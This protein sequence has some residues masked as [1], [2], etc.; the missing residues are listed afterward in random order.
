MDGLIVVFGLGVGL[1][2]GTTGVGGRSVMTPLLIL[3]AGVQPV[4]AVGTDLAHG[5]VTKTLGGWQH[6]RQGSVSLGISLWMAAGS[7]PA[8]LGGCWCSASC[9]RPTAATSTR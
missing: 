8:A 5:A 1:L 3:A 9:T 6:L 7:I 2:V 4:L